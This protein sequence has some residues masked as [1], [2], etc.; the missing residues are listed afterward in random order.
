MKTRIYKEVSFDA[1]HRL[2]HYE[3]KCYNLHGHRWRV[4]VWIEGDVDEETMIL[5]DY[6]TIKGI[7]ER[8]DHQVILN[9]EDPMVPC[10]RAFQEVVT[11]PGDPTSELLAGVMVDLLNRECRLNGSTAQVVRI[12]VW[13]SPTCYAE[14]SYADQ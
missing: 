13:E 10:I 6:N 8:F 7:I 3:G 5:V 11:T 2:L 1:T 9:E 14:I 12:R 4:E